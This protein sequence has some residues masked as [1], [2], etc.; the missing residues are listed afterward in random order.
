MRLQCQYQFLW[1]TSA[2]CAENNAPV[3]GDGCRV[4]DPVSGDVYDLGSLNGSDFHVSAG[5]YTYDISVC[6]ALLNSTGC[7]DDQ[8]G[9]CQ[10]KGGPDGFAYALG[11]YSESPTFRSGM[12]TLEYRGGAACHNQ[13]YQRSVLITFVC[14]A[15]AGIGAPLFVS[16]LGNCT[17]TFV[18]ETEAACGVSSEE[19][20]CGA[21]DVSSGAY[22]DLSVLTRTQ[23]NWEVVGQQGGDEYLYLLNVCHGINSDGSTCPGWSGACQTKPSDGNFRGRGLGYPAGPEWR[24]GSLVLEYDS[25]E[26]CHGSA[27]NRSVLVS[28]MCEAGTLG[29]P[30]FLRETDEVRG[31]ASRAG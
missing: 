5:G 3:V 27:Y 4:T 26:A 17:Y 25:G 19:I 15:G 28:F 10:R 21:L 30:R 1:S 29:V 18:W 24:D 13:Q 9:A 6:S 11:K 23:G 7:G 22:Y 2:A 20:E 14:R 8:A 31:R 16:E 12:L